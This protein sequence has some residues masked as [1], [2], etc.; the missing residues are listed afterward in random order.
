VTALVPVG[1]LLKRGGDPRVL[2]F[3]VSPEEARSRF[4]RER[5]IRLER[6][7]DGLIVEPEPYEYRWVALFVRAQG[8]QGQAAFTRSDW[9]RA[10]EFFESARA[11]D[12]DPPSLEII[13]LLGVSWYLLN[14]FDR[15]EPLL[16]QSLRLGPSARQQIRACT[17]LSSICLKQGRKAEAM[18]WQEQ[19][20]AVV[21]ADPELKREFEQF[22]R[23]R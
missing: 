9:R 1:P 18:R 4:G 10:A 11:A 22:P 17:C 3:P 19:A 8:R 6:L 5:G 23:P 7:P 12:P 20:M 16:K 2:P 15:A 14:E 13:H 21:G